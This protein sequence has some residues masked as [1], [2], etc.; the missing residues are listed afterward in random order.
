MP[1]PLIRVTHAVRVAAAGAVRILK[2][3]PLLGT[4][5]ALGGLLVFMWITMSDMRALAAD[6]NVEQHLK[7][8]RQPEERWL[9]MQGF[10][11]SHVTLGT[12]CLLPAFAVALL[13]MRGTDLV[14]PLT[15]AGLWVGLAWIGNDFIA[16]WENVLYDP[17]GMDASPVP[18]FI[19]LALMA[20][21]VLSPPL[22][23]FAYSRST[24]LD[25]YL[26]RNFAVPFLLCTGGIAGIMITMD[27]LNNANDF[28]EVKFKLTDVLAYYLRQLPLILTTIMEPAVLLATLYAL[29]RMSR[30]NELIAMITSGRSVLRILT[31]L[32]AA[33]VWCSLAVVALNFEMAP[34]S[35]R[36]QEEMIKEAREAVSARSKKRKAAAT[37]TEQTMTYNVLY[38]NR[39]A[40]RTWYFWRV[41]LSARTAGRFSEVWVLEQDP[42]GALLNAIFARNAAWNPE[43]G[44]WQFTQAW[45][46]RFTS[47]QPA[48]RLAHPERIYRELIEMRDPIWPETPGTILSNRLDP[49]HL[50][51]PE[52]VSWLRTNEALPGAARARF[53]VAKHWR[54]ALPFRCFL[55]VLIAA[56][57]GIVAS[58]RNMLGGVSAAVGLFILAFF[59]STVVLKAGEGAYLPPM[60]AAWGVNLVFGA[61][62][63]VIFW[64]RAKGR[65]LPSLNPLTWFPRGPLRT[66]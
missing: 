9:M 19:K 62:G 55:M 50:G 18:Y 52:L 53:E 28:V 39:E 47:G 10:F 26:V 44:V 43:T 46:Y 7:F 3:V 17:M 42:S 37:E 15:L 61:A 56:P 41:S 16:N 59:L 60:A 45:E 30:H 25:R 13:R 12:W 66:S 31:P 40:H 48:Q 20:L 34:Q 58:R 6:A 65:P 36:L 51:V 4:V 2:A 35:Q 22:L 32:L 5:L 29:G 23:V 49:E 8:A 24:I 14:L 57:L 54:V 33:G 64:C 1:S 11:R 27:L 63:A 38:R 21:L